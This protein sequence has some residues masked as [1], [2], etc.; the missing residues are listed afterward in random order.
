M[1]A[2]VILPSSVRLF[3]FVLIDVNKFCWTFKL[4]QIFFHS[5][6][7]VSNPDFIFN[8]S[9]EV[10]NTSDGVS[11]VNLTALLTVN[12]VKPVLLVKI[13]TRM[14]GSREYDD[15]Y[16]KSQLD[17]C[18]MENGS[19]GGIVLRTVAKSIESHSNFYFDCKIEKKFLYINNYP[20]FDIKFLT[21]FSRKIRNRT[22][23]YELSI[24]VKVKRNGRKSSDN[25]LSAKIFGKIIL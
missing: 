2:A 9:L 21:I 4:A 19:L 13:S 5:S 7:I 20:V 25:V 1:A 17:L 6:K 18:K 15:E 24:S 16:Y 12:L 22:P 11:C 8:S 3:E 23:E 14:N 10:F